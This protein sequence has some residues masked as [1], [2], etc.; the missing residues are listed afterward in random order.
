[1]MRTFAAVTFT[2]E[3]PALRAAAAGFLSPPPPNG[4]EKEKPP[5]GLGTAAG[6]RM[7]NERMR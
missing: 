5:A 4:R 7:S 1:M 3:P 2:A 6:C